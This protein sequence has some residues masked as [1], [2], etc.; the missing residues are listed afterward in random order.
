MIAIR[1]ARRNPVRR[2]DSIE[3]MIIQVADF[4]IRLEG[5]AAL[6]ET[7]RVLYGAFPRPMVD[8]TA[9]FIS[10]RQCRCEWG[11]E[12]A[13]VR[14][15]R[16]ANPTHRPAITALLIG[17]ILAAADASLILLHGNALYDPSAERLLLLSGD[18]GSG[19]STLS[20]YLLRESDKWTLAAE[21]LILLHTQDRGALYPFPRAATF[22]HEN[23]PDNAMAWKGL[24][25]RADGKSLRPFKSAAPALSGK[26]ELHR[27]DVVLLT[28]KP[29][30]PSAERSRNAGQADPDT[31]RREGEE[32]WI[33]AAEQSFLDT[34]RAESL[35]VESLHGIRDEHR[36]VFS[37]PLSATQRTVFARLLEQSGILLFRYG[38]SG[39]GRMA[40]APFVFPPEPSGRL[41]TATEGLQCLWGQRVVF[42]PDAEASS[43]PEFF[44]LAR[45]LSNATYYQFA[46]GGT[47]RHSA[48]TLRALLGH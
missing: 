24:G 34:L 38:K 29:E 18:S 5:D 7:C 19:K 36:L 45:A 27:V 37:R 39:H 2:Y 30:G 6:L 14:E 40:D 13:W 22:R 15:T 26:I 12:D 44:R 35:P 4:S 48:K 47:P 3:T 31:P 33:S 11:R 42:S 10:W 1:R 20:H 25:S 17:R 8:V 9:Y 16:V 28:R 41:L 32:A 43:V 21:D 23:A 46:P